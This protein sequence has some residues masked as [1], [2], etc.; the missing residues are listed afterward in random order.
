LRGRG[1]PL[2]PRPTTLLGLGR[3]LTSLFRR[4]NGPAFGARSSL[5]WTA[6]RRRSLRCTWCTGLLTPRLGRCAGCVW[7]LR[8]R[9]RCA[10]LLRFAGGSQR[11]FPKPPLLAWA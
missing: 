11:V 4:R 6:G 8:A 7:L 5:L 9:C 3:R 2:A 10:G 1:R